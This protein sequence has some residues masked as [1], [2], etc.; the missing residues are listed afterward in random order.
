MFP[1]REKAEFS[2]FSGYVRV[3]LHPRGPNCR[4]SWTRPWKK[5][6]PKRSFL[7]RSGLLQPLKNCWSLIGSFRYDRSRFAR[8]PF[9]LSFVILIPFCRIVT[10]NSSDGYD[11]NHRRK[12]LLTF[13][14]TKSSS[15]IRSN[16]GIQLAA[17]WQ[18]CNTTQ[19]PF[20]TPSVINDWA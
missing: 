14:G 15:Q 6:R 10:G 8:R 16:F 17:K 18:F 11:V 4:R 13:P 19:W 2:A 7:H 5:H 9:G 1:R 3:N 20:W 12:S